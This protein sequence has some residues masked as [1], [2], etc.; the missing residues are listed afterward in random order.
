MKKVLL[1]L[2]LVTAF[3]SV[4]LAQGFHLGVKGG[5][6]LGKING[7]SFKDEFR[8]GYQLGGFMEID[9]TK[10]FGIQPEVLFSQTNTT[11]TD[12]PL[13]G[14]KPGET[15]HLNYM[16]I[17]ILLRF[18]ASKL[19]TF[20]LGPQFSILTDN[21]K[22]TL[23]NAGDAFKSGDFAMVAGAQVN[24]GALRV[25]GRYNI[26]LNSL[27]AITDAEKWRRQELQFG[28]GMKIF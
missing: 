26:G 15:Y 5:A 25:Y 11:V 13:S 8:L 1:S 20:N 24:L 17:P 3:T 6:N 28:L 22:T 16:N 27:N 4:T 2:L 19:L 12:E 9:F 14:L 10:G 18:N 21:H 7:E 23:E